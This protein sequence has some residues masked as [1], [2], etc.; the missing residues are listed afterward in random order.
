MPLVLQW[1]AGLVALPVLKALGRR[2]MVV[3]GVSLVTYTGVAA[4]MSSVTSAVASNYGGLAADVLAVLG[5][6]HIPQALNVVFAAVSA[7]LVLRGLDASGSLSRWV[8]GTPTV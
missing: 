5:I 3:L 7:R 2:L 1:L 6:A 4:L 8:V